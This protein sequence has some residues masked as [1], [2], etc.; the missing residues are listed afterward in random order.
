MSKALIVKVKETL[1]EL[2]ALH[3]KSK[4]IEKPR[5]YMLIKIKEA[6]VNGVSKNRLMELVGASSQSIHTWRTNYIKGG[7]HLLLAHKKG[8][9]KA[10]SF[11]S[12]EKKKLKNL[13]HN[14]ENNIVGYK[15]LQQWVKNEF[16]KEIKYN[17]LLKYM[18]ATF[19]TKIKVARKTHIKKDEQAVETFK[20]TSIQS[21]KKR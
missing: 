19:N 4:P 18:V 15:E 7:L 12:E 2:K 8:G 10:S 1:K 5:L 21:A 14:P 11:N 20:K 6:G 9:Y 3:K 17:T 13:V 16:K